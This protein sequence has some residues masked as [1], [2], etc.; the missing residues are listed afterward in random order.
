MALA[1]V[2]SV[3]FLYG[4]SIP[5]NIASIGKPRKPVTHGVAIASVTI[6][7][8]AIAGLAYVASQL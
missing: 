7:L 1:I 4:L 6:A 3:A 8:L 2:C 5:L